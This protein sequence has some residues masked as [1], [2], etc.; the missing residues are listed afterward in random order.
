MEVYGGG[1]AAA[2][3]A[4]EGL[5]EKLKLS[6]NQKDEEGVAIQSLRKSARSRRSSNCICPG[7]DECVVGL[8][9]REKV[10][11]GTRARLIQQG[12]RY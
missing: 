7:T 6:Q 11:A 1:A 5:F 10:M 9:E 3:V 2:T 4:W 12:N 8:G